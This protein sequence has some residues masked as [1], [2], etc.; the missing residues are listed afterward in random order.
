MYIV[1][2]N[3]NR[4]ADSDSDYDYE[5]YKKTIEAFCREVGGHTNGGVDETKLFAPL[6][7]TGR[8]SAPSSRSATALKGICGNVKRRFFIP[9]A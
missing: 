7:P 3:V 8:I 1:Y 9:R 5:N 2:A 6:H 4:S